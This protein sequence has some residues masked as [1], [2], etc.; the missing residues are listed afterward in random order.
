MLR[1]PGFLNSIRKYQMTQ[2]IDAYSVNKFVTR[3]MQ[4]TN[5]RLR[6]LGFQI[7]DQKFKIFAKK[8]YFGRKEIFCPK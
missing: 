6:E 3:R 8:I 2:N 1:I 5:I 7:F 4:K